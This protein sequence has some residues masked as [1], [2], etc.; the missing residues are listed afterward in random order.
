M[1]TQVIIPAHNEAS[2]IGALLERLPA[3]LVEPIVAVNGSDDRTAEIARR[4]TANVYDFEEAGKLRTVQKVLRNRGRAALDPLLLIDADTIPFFP[5]RWHDIML[6]TMH[7]AGE[8]PVVVSAPVLFT[9]H[10][11][12]RVAPVIRSIYRYGEVIASKDAARRTGVGGGQYGPNMGLHLNRV[13]ALDAVLDLP[14]IWPEMDVAYTQ[15]IVESHH[16]ATF[17]QILHLGATALTPEP[18]A[19]VPIL[20]WLKDPVSAHEATRQGYVDTRKNMQAISYQDW[21]LSREA[22]D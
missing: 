13:A 9:K 2:R 7:P 15:A 21:L 5:R 8:S 16:Q 11:A 22:E 20:D 12:G 1:K 17:E 19:M 18:A 4:F 10:K 3:D 6:K 14:D